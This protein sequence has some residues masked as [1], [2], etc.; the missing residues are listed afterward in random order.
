MNSIDALLNDL[1]SGAI[2]AETILDQCLANID[3][4]AGEG[5][6]VMLHVHRDSARAAAQAEDI[7][8]R[9][10]L[11][12]GPLSG[13]PVSIKDLCDIAGD[14]TKAGSVVL[15]DA[16]PAIEDAPIVKR[17]RAAGAVIVGRTNMTE[18]AYSG[19]GINPHYDTPANPH[20][21]ATRRIPGGSSSGAAVSVTDGMAAIGMGTDTGG[22]CRIPAALCGT[23]G[24]KPTAKRIPIDG[25]VPLSVSL[26]SVGSMGPTVSCVARFDAIVAG[27]EFVPLDPL[28]VAGLRLGLI[29]NV[30]QNGMDEHVRTQFFNA[31]AKLEAA[32][33]QVERVEV[34]TINLL[35]LLLHKGGIASAE[36]YTWHA[37]LLAKGADQYDPRVRFRVSGGAAQSATEYMNTVAL[38]K[39][40]IQQYIKEVRRF[41]AMIMPTV[42]IVAP[43]MA[44]F[45][46]DDEFFR[47]NG[48]LLRN[49][50]IANTL[51]LCAISIPCHTD[52]LPV[53]FGMFGQHM[54]DRR[55]LEIAAGVEGTLAEN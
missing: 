30:V 12:V 17:L 41:D 35:G 21:R 8:R 23:V 15:K 22:S 16:A 18:F 1:D 37:P 47:L 11:P 36:A 24:Y 27:E 50:A 55:L 7:K 38:R 32:G 19:V 31:V 9:A 40:L 29:E 49:T 6:R 25:I 45:A 10:G 52:G 54:G 46:Q 14:V 34:Q 28:P 44:A 33:A 5:Q 3:D 4:S 53:G 2:S 43:P 13:I 51:D 48:L 39:Q 42:P 26:D 20:D